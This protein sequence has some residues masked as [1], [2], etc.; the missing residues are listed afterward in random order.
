MYPSS[1]LNLHNGDVIGAT[2]TANVRTGLAF[3]SPG[4]T[5]NIVL[6]KD[7]RV[8]VLDTVNVG[9]TSTMLGNVS[10]RMD[11]SVKTVAYSS[12]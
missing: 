11:G 4:G 10:V 12:N 1:L 8:P 9:L 2:N 5:A 7:A 6:W 3:A